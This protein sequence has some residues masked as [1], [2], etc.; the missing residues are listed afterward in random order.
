MNIFT[1]EKTHNLEL[2][3]A[4]ENIRFTAAAINPDDPRRF[5]NYLHVDESGAI[6]G[7]DGHRLH[8]ADISVLTDPEKSAERWRLTPGAWKIETMTKSKITLIREEKEE[9]KFPKYSRVIE[10]L[11]LQPGETHTINKYTRGNAEMKIIA[12]T[13]RDWTAGTDPSAPE[14]ER[15]A[16][17]GELTDAGR[18]A[19]ARRAA[20][21]YI[22]NI[23][24]L[25]PIF[26]T[27]GDWTIQ[28]NAEP[29]G[30]VYF[31]NCTKSAIIMPVKN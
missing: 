3:E 26:Q 24:Y 9:I 28:R 15:D 4:A 2:M 27:G 16:E 6:W 25:K 29:G 18:A 1:M 8:A 30:P 5:M 13:M 19:E 22:L 21:D 14:P 7:T 23:E 20:A 31:H 11:K 17:T 12:A 10:S